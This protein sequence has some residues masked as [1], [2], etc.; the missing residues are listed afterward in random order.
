M[1]TKWKSLAANER[2]NYGISQA[3]MYQMYAYSK[4]YKTPEIWLL[5]PVNDEMRGHSEIGFDSGDGTKVRIHF[6]D[7]TRTEENLE[8]LKSKIAQGSEAQS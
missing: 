1:D 8:E 4:R 7:V 2:K 6:V 3:D 5:Y